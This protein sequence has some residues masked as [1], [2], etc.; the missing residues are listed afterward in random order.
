[1]GRVK[2]FVGL[3]EGTF[4]F[5]VP[6]RDEAKIHEEGALRRIYRVADIRS[7]FSTRPPAQAR[8]YF[9]YVCVCVCV[10]VA[11]LMF[12]RRENPV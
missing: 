5:R 4:F 9:V 2:T 8:V 10:Y 6:C 7:R 3:R 12:Y 11:I 1:M